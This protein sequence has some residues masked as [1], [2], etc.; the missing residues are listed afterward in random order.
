MNQNFVTSEEIAREKYTGCIVQRLLPRTLLKTKYVA[1]IRKLKKELTNSLTFDKKLTEKLPDVKIT[2][3]HSERNSE[4][5]ICFEN[6]QNK[7]KFLKLFKNTDFEPDASLSEFDQER[8]VT[9]IQS[10]KQLSHLLP[11]T[12]L[13]LLKSMTRRGTLLKLKFPLQMQLE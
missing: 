2:I 5:K 10:K 9:E 7:A 4:I 3:F 13:Q 8:A 11:K 6:K 1:V 12:Y